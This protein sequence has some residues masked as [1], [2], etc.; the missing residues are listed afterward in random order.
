MLIKALSSDYIP[1]W[2][3]LAEELES[4]FQGSMVNDE[5]FHKFMKKKIEEKEVFMALDRMNNLAVMGIIA[6]SNQK[7]SISW[8][9]VFEKYQK[10]RAGSKL[11]ESAINQ[12]DPKKEVDVITFRGDDPNGLPAIRIYQKFG[13]EINSNVIHHDLPRCLMKRPPALKK[14]KSHSFHHN[15][16]RYLDWENPE[17][18]PV[19][20]KLQ[21]PKDVIVIQELKHSWLEASIYAQGS[22]WG[23]CHVLSKK[24]FVELYE[25]PKSDMV[26]FM[27]D[28]QMTAKALKTI[29]KAERINYELHGNSMPHMHMHLF[30]RYIDD[31]FPGL[32]IDYKKIEPS[33]YSDEKDFEYFIEQMRDLLQKE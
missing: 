5:E 20:L 23:K 8:F 9:G 25:M 16:K 26:N 32:S 33:P 30:P 15:Y 17:N 22:I 2:L 18:C 21:G 19:C 6:F 14:Y 28:V 12:L 7:S 29:T 10:K 27:S 3:D 11:L 13:F 31:L 4:I 1:Q 24:H